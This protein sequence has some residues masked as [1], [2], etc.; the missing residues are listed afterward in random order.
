MAH[1]QQFIGKATYDF[2]VDG[3][4]ADTA[5]TPAS[6]FTIP[7]NAIITE[8]VSHVSTVMASGGSAT[9]AFTIGGVTLQAAQA[10]NHADFSNEDVISIL[11]APDKTTASGQLVVTTAGS[12]ALTAGVFSV[13]VTYILALES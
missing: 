8:C 5:I 10:F 11:D 13:Y 7:N 1:V 6:N 9:V 3:G 2:S 12:A 4:A